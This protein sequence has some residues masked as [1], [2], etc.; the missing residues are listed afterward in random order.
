VV[1]T[2]PPMPVTSTLLDQAHHAINRTLLMMKAFPHPNSNQKAFLTGLARLYNVVPYQCR[3]M[4]A[5]PCGGEVAGGKVPTRD[6][7][8]HLQILTS[9]GFR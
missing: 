4:H 6:W 8:L 1:L 7:L 2:D 5:G 9:G 3:A